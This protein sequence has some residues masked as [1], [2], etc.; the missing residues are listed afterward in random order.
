MGGDCSPDHYL[1]IANVRE[2]LSVSKQAA[3]KFDIE[4]LNLKKLNEMKD[5]EES[6]SSVAAAAES[7]RSLSDD[8]SIASSKASSLQ[9]TI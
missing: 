4:R 7:F 8:R 5:E 2:R 9:S 1:V 6:S 3:Q